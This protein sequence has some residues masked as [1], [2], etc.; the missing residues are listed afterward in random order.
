MEGRTRPR[1]ASASASA[2]P[3]LQNLAVLA[4]RAGKR[5][6]GRRLGHGREGM[7]WDARGRGEG[8]LRRA[9]PELLAGA[10]GMGARSDEGEV[11][12]AAAG[13]R[14]AA[15]AAVVGYRSERDL[16]RDGGGR[17]GE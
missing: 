16:E 3:P 1:A 5:D 9:P 14:P 8:R 13:R 2:S 12:A 10:V 7:G 17:G 11:A 6:G 15:A 4:A